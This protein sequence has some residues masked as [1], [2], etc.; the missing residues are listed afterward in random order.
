MTRGENSLEENIRRRENHLSEKD[1]QKASID[2]EQKSTMNLTNAANRRLIGKS[3]QIL[4]D[5]VDSD[6]TD[7]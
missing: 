7:E 5:G 2:E 1:L 3:V 4:E 6:Q